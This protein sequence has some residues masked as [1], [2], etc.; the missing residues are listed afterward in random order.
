MTTIDTCAELIDNS[1][2]LFK[3]GLIDRAYSDLDTVF[4]WLECTAKVGEAYKKVGVTFVSKFSKWNKYYYQGKEITCSEA[5]NIAEH[6]M[7][8]LVVC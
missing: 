8:R 3:L 6:A 1:E 7:K 5:L 4:E 2:A